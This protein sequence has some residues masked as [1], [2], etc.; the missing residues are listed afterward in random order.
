MRRWRLVRWRVILR[1]IVIGRDWRAG[2]E[3]G[4]LGLLCFYE[5][6]T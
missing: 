6:R 1:R 5:T 4:Q 3:P 2:D